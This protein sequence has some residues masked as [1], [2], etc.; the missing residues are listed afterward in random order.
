MS[1]ELNLRFCI[2]VHRRP[3][4][5][6]CLVDPGKPFGRSLVEADRVANRRRDVWLTGKTAAVTLVQKC[7]LCIA[8]TGGP[9]TPIMS[10]VEVRRGSRTSYTC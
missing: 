7:R 10:N 3:I 1:Y 6:L 8:L 2:P 5:F 9:S 4:L